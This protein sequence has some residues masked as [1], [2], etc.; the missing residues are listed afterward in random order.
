[1]RR[2]LAAATLLLAAGLAGA[3]AAGAFGGNARAPSLR[4]DLRL[5]KNAHCL[6]AQTRRVG[7]KVVRRFHAVTAVSCPDGFRVYPGRGQWEVRIREVAVSGIPA[8]QR[9]F[10]QPND[11]N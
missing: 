2:A 1:M 11:L 5:T 9:Y 6:G 3:Y 8:W 10:E 4:T 7:P